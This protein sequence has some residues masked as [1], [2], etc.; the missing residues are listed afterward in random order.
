[1]VA[2]LGLAANV[3]DKLDGTEEVKALFLLGKNEQIRSKSETYPPKSFVIFKKSKLCCSAAYLIMDAASGNVLSLK[4][5]LTWMSSFSSG[6]A[7]SQPSL[8]S[9]NNS[10]IDEVLEASEESIS[11]RTIFGRCN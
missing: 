7:S 10:S 8:S 4:K 5:S 2:V 11:S 6:S 9:R 1:L 3:V